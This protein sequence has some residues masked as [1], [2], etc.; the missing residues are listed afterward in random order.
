MSA[1]RAACPTMI[2]RS[3]IY[4]GFFEVGLRSLKLG[5]V[6]GFICADRWIRNQYGRG[7]RQFVSGAYSVEVLITM[8]DVDAFHEQVSAYPAISILRR[9][10]QGAPVVAD[11]KRS[12]TSAEASEL[13]V[14][15]RR[16]GSRRVLNDRYEA[17]RLPGWLDGDSPWPAG[18]RARLALIE[19]LNEDQATGTRVGIGVAT[20]ADGVFLT[21]DA[22]AEVERERLLPLAM[23]RDTASGRLS[24]SGHYLV[25]PWDNA[26][27][28][29]DLNAW[30]QLRAYY[31][32]HMSTLRGRHVAGKRPHEWYR[33]ID[34]VDHALTRKPKLLFPDMKMNSHPV[35]DEGGIYPHHNLYYIVSR[36]WDLRVLGGLLLSRVA[37]AFVE[38]Y[39]V[40][41]RGGT[42]RFQAQYLRLIRVPRPDAVSAADS[43]ALARAFDERNVR[44]A[45]QAALRVYA[46][47]DRGLFG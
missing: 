43:E 31:E 9:K 12:F 8:H 6:L 15:A 29:V 16:K 36:A 7:L 2:G 34:K 10:R 20:G 28:L 22:N 3:D 35:L 18:S 33:T 32:R 5:G 47:N 19:D 46:V 1:Y 14:W 11:T 45:T 21:T 13:V 17:A 39:A 25:D 24:W 30:P 40:R 27:R 44:A 4:V 37:Q 41:M 23:A 26:G 42:L 38:A